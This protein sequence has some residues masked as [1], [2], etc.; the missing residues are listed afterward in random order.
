MAWTH[1]E[2]NS[3]VLD[4]YRNLV[5]TADKNCLKIDCPAIF[6]NQYYIHR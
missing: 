4:E 2:L 3:Y 5:L 1:L 6:N